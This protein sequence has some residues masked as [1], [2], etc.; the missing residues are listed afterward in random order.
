MQQLIALYSLLIT[1]V[2]YGNH[3]ER[4]TAY[5]LERVYELNPY[6]YNSH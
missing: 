6:I 4:F 5:Y 1:K 2:I 3:K